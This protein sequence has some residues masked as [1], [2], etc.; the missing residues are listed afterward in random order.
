MTSKNKHPLLIYD[1]KAADVIDFISLT[2]FESGTT[3]APVPRNQ[4]LPTNAKAR[5]TGNCILVATSHAWF[6]QCHPDPD[7]MKLDLIKEEFGP[8]LRKR[9]PHTKI[10]IFDD[11]HSCPQ[12]PRETKAEEER[13]QAA[14]KHMNS[15]YVYCDVVLFLH[16]PLPNLDEDLRVCH[17]VPSE[18]EWLRFLDTLQY[19]EAKSN[20]NKK[21][22]IQ[23]NDIVT[24]MQGMDES[25]P[26]T[27]EDLQK[28]KESTVI[29]FLKRPYGR[30]NRT[31]ADERGWLFAHS[32][33]C[34]VILYGDA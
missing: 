28:K 7:G 24:K 26:L 23:K 16:A 27:I 20:D 15:I 17:L 34:N 29:W 21:V 30:P 10:L 5:L 19:V 3:K 25:R 9:Y 14:M 4:D 12:W 2:Y 11:W 6:H 33:E 13:F 22:K 31:P 32:N 1:P 8:R 18:H